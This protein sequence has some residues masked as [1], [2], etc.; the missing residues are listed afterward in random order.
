MEEY[1]EVIMVTVLQM[2]LEGIILAIEVVA[3]PIRDIMAAMLVTLHPEEG[4]QLLLRVSGGN[5]SNSK[6]Y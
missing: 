5:I 2:I 4:D 3:A 6:R 1:R